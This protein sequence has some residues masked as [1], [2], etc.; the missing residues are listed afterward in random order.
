MHCQKNVGLRLKIGDTKTCIIY[1]D[2]NDPQKEDTG[3]A[4]ERKITGTKYMS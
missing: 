1:V 2:E 3:D 4:N